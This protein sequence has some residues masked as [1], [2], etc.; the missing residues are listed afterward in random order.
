MSNHCPG[1]ENNKSLTEITLKCPECSATMDVFSD[2][3][4]KVKKCPACSAKVDPKSC[5]VDK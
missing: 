1:F 2:E 5:Q 3:L 4:E